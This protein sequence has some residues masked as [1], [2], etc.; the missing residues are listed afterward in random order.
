MTLRVRI[1]A[2]ASVAVALAVLAAAVGV[3][4]AVRSD[5]RA[6]IDGALTQRAQAFAAPPPFHPA[7]GPAGANPASRRD[8]EATPPPGGGGGPHHRDEGFP[9]AVEPA[10]FGGASGY[11]QFISPQGAV[12]VP[13]GQGS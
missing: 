1:A 8:G 3:Y 6:Q 4:L 2:S 10:R 12:A 9:R 5:L 11:V 13:G 7:P